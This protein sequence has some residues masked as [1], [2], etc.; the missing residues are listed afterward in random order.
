MNYWGQIQMEWCKTTTNES[1][2]DECSNTLKTTGDVKS[3]ESYSAQAKNWV[4]CFAVVPTKIKIGFHSWQ[5]SWLGCATVISFCSRQNAKK[6]FSL[7]NQI[8]FRK[9]KNIGF[10][11]NR[12]WIKIAPT[13]KNKIYSGKVKSRWKQNFDGNILRG[14]KMGR[15]EP[16]VGSNPALRW[17]HSFH[18]W[19]ILFIQTKAGMNS[20]K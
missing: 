15:W 13:A 18:G 19:V 3:N 6:L 2:W 1:L 12:R 16:V 10:R 20:F 17:G 8:L 14:K 7:Q 5:S 11:W 9:L 4:T